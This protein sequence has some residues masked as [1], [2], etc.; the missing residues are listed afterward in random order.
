[1]PDAIQNDPISQMQNLIAPGAVDDVLSQILGVRLDDDIGRFR[2]A[3]AIRFPIRIDA[4]G[5]KT[6]DYVAPSYAVQSLQ[7]GIIPATGAQAGIQAQAAL[8]VTEALVVLKRL[9]PLQCACDAGIDSLRDLVRRELEDLPRLF[10]QDLGPMAHRIDMTFKQLTGTDFDDD[11]LPCSPDPALAGGQLGTLRKRMGMC[12]SAQTIDDEKIRTDFRIFVSYVWM[13]QTA[14]AA[15]RSDFDSVGN[16]SLGSVTRRLSAT[17][18]GIAFANREVYAALDA[19]RI[20]AAERL[21][22]TLDSRPPITLADLLSWIDEV[23]SAN[24]L[25]VIA[26]GQDGIATFAPVVEELLDLVCGKLKPAVEGTRTAGDGDSD[27][28]DRLGCAGPTFLSTHRIKDAV[29][30]LAAQ[31]EALARE[32]R[33]ALPASKA[34]KRRTEYKAPPADSKAPPTDSKKR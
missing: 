5:T 21:T 27:A 23:A 34:P 16:D 8:L 19:A 17:L 25:A 13:L 2:A 31:L 1:M 14:W 28:D 12:E 10:G 26:A 24:G 7:S 6:I 33:R 9:R 11:D 18:L 22:F 32:T 29:N 30:R 3:L 15:M 4:A 20:G